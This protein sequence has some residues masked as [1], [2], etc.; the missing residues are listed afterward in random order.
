MGLI[1]ILSIQAR[2]YENNGFYWNKK[3]TVKGFFEPSVSVLYFR[4]DEVLE[5]F[6]GIIFEL[7]N[8]DYINGYTSSIVLFAK[9]LQREIFY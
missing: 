6:S 3:R 9:F 1:L 7:K 8:S 4:S 5:G 2:F